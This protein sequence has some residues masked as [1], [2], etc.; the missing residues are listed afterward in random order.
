MPSYPMSPVLVRLLKFLIVVLLPLVLIIA[1]VRFL[2]SDQYLAFEYSKTNFPPD[3]YGFDQAQRLAYASTNFRYVRAGQPIDTLANQQLNG[4]PLYTGRELKH[5]QDVQSV[6]QA[7]WR[8]WQLALILI[9][10]LVFALAWRGET[11]PALYAALR[12]GGLLA[13]GLVALIGG[14]AVVAWQLWFVAFHRIFF[15]AG[16]WT[17]EYSDTLIRLFPEKFWF[18]AAVTIA[19]VSLVGSLLV[20]LIGWRLKPGIATASANAPLATV[21]S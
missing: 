16:T 7:I 14:L 3:P 17:F 20:A 13:A 11:R 5:M 18:D 21:Q 6:Y 9:L 2:V 1:S 8:I 10:L 4:A 15:A 19:A 12:W